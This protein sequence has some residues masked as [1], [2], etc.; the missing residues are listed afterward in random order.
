MRTIILSLIL[1]QS[2]FSNAQLKI[3]L[4]NDPSMDITNTTVEISGLPSD[5]EITYYLKVINIGGSSVSTK[6]RRTEVDVMSG[7]ENTTCWVLCP[8]YVLAGTQPILVSEFAATINPLDTNNTFAGHY[9]P[10]NQTGCSLIK[11]EWVEESNETNVYATIFIRFVHGIANCTADIYSENKIYNVSLY[12][13]P[14]SDATTLL[15]NATA[16]GQTTIVIY[17][18]LGEIVWSQ[19]TTIVQGENRINLDLS[20]MST[21]NYF[22]KINT[23]NSVITKKIEVVR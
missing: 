18:L 5:N 4:F 15:F 11:Y 20:G 8:S 17:N 12:P 2:A 16:G 9:K 6:V 10:S 3:A 19:N 7:T 13:N 23:S 1:L 14:T 22:V 21:G